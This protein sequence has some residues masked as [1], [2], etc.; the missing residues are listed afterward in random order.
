MFSSQEI[1]NRYFAFY[2]ARGHKE[3]PNVSLVPE[4][5][6][7]LL[8]VN[9]GMFPLVPFLSGETHPLGKRLVNIQRSL[10]FEDIEEVGITNRHTTCFH[11]IGNWSLGDYFKAD[12]L[13]WVYQFFI[14]EL[15]LD[16]QR[17]F[18][19]V[20]A[21]DEYAPKDMESIKIIQT[22]FKKYGIDAKEN[23]RIFACG[24]ADNWWQRGDAPGELGGPDSEIFY[25][26]GEG[27]GI[28]KHPAKHQDE[29]LEIGNSVFMQY[30]K[31]KTGWEELPQKN[32]DFGGG[33]E[34]L[35]LV[36]QNKKDIYETDN[37]WPI[38]QKL[39]NLSG[40][41]YGEN[42]EITFAMRV[43]AD[44]I[45]AA[46]LL[47]MDGVVPSNKDQGYVLRRYIRRMVRFSPAP[48]LLRS[49]TKEL[50]PIVASTLSWLYPELPSKIKFI[51]DLFGDEEEKFKK[52][53]R[54]ALPK[55]KHA[56]ESYKTL[57][58]LPQ[59]SLS[60][61]IFNLYQSTGYPPEM[62]VEEA[63]TRGV[64]K[65]ESIK[66]TMNEH[67]K[68]FEKHKE[69]SRA[70]AEKKFKGGL[71]DHSEQVTKYHTATHLLHEALRRVLGTH[72]MQQGSNITAERLRFD[73]THTDKLSDEQIKA[74]EQLMND[75]IKQKLPVNFTMLKREQAEKS[76]A[77]HFFK[78]KYG[79]MVKVYYIG[80][81]LEKAFSKEF[82]GGPH[83]EN[84]LRLSP[85]LIIYKQ[86]A[87]GK[88][89]RRVYVKFV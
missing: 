26:L 82:C 46:T 10:R 18:A 61:L 86:E 60:E 33:L 32:V 55:V 30:R 65:K 85:T 70:G 75:T 67:N 40:K 58:G 15:G 83:V 51:Q 52:T 50:T 14:E 63:V 23:E 9:S 3:T 56:L 81:S 36:A 64:L 25:Y 11:M 22:V 5:D 12:Q 68:I 76:G 37:F 78:E 16:P 7:T 59:K 44:H 74:V 84:L 24:R 13:P 38:V 66:E 77:L 43:V 29:F 88:G 53:L 49:T 47:A 62:A 20:F 39:E 73:F 69:L 71:A 79:D 1:L 4:G 21:G 54:N 31:T 35:A 80:E 8:F 48:E 27:S 17:L 19:T 45:R 87:I 57:S 42:A 89:V 72:V 6:S 28:G 2:K 34:R 41:K